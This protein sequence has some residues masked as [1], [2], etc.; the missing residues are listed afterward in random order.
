MFDRQRLHEKV[1]YPVVRVFTEKAVGSGT[2]IYSRPSEEKAEEYE[3]YVLTNHHVIENL[4][5]YKKE[6]DP[7]LQRDVKREIKAAGSVQEFRYRPGRTVVVGESSVQADVVAYDVRQDLALL[8][9]RDIKQYEYVAELWTREKPLEMLMELYCV[10]CGLGQRPL[11]THG[12]LSG[13]GIEI[14]NYDYMLSTAASVFGNCLPGDTVVHTDKGPKEIKDIQAG[15]TV[16][17]YTPEGITKAKVSKLINSGPKKVYKLVTAHRTIR[18][19]DNH[20]FLVAVNKGKA[21]VNRGH[22]GASIYGNVWVLEWKQLKDLRKGDVIVA[23]DAIPEEFTNVEYPDLKGVCEFSEDFM[24]VVGGF[25]GDGYVRVRKGEGGE[26]ALNTIRRDK[27]EY[28]R[29]L[30]ERVFNKTVTVDPKRGLYLYSAAVARLFDSLGLNKR[31]TEKEIPAWIY[32]L[33]HK[34]LKAMLEGYMHTDGYI[35]KTGAWVFEANN[36]RLMKQLREIC[37][38]LGYVVSNIFVRE[39]TGCL[40]VDGTRT[41][42]ITPTALSASFQAYPEY[43]K[44]DS[45]GSI[46]GGERIELP[47]NTRMERVSKIVYE[48]M[49]ETYDIVVDSYHNFFAE[50]VLVH[51]SGGAVFVVDTLQFAGVPSRIS[52]SMLGYQAITHMGYFIPVSRVY[53]FLEEQCFQFIYDTTYTPSKCASL[54][55][56]KRERELAEYKSKVA[57]GAEQEE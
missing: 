45:R 50:G 53:D 6:W 48:G 11:M 43:Q 37:I 56:K 35:D 31:S 15:D 25:L 2:I 40:L 27:Q 22:N 47:E 4:L 32:K 14:D 38:R 41:I 17:S 28:F 8:K 13:M 29:A 33:P 3:T 52:V 39:R 19:S 42:E 21:V 24:K 5:S 30:L 26:F 46:S 34:Y 1:L 10:G 12:Y 9:L 44:A 57:A 23:L 54:R 7:V 55:E 20:P 49:E 51:N 16:F 36:V 18:A